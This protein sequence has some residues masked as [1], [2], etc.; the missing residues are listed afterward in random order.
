MT[1]HTRYVFPPMR[2]AGWEYHEG[3]RLTELPQVGD[4]LSLKPEPGNAHDAHAIEVF[5]RK[6]KIGYVPAYA[7]KRLHGIAARHDTICVTKR[8]DAPHGFLEFELSVPTPATLSALAAPR[9]PPVAE[10]SGTALLE[11]AVGAQLL[12]VLPETLTAAGADAATAAADVTWAFERFAEGATGGRYDAGVPISWSANQPVYLVREPAEARAHER[13]SVWLPG[14]RRLGFLHRNVGEEAITYLDARDPHRLHRAYLREASPGGD[15]FAESGLATFGLA[16]Y[17]LYPAGYASPVHSEKYDG[18]A[19]AERYPLHADDLLIRHPDAPQSL[20]TAPFL[21]GD[22]KELWVLK[23]RLPR[24]DNFD[25]DGKYLHTEDPQDADEAY[26]PFGKT[27]AAAAAPKPRLPRIPAGYEYQVQ[28]IYSTPYYEQV[29]GQSTE[30]L[31][32]VLR[33]R[34][35]ERGLPPAIAGLPDDSRSGLRY[36]DDTFVDEGLPHGHYVFAEAAA[37]DADLGAAEESLTPL[38][39]PRA[40]GAPDFRPAFDYRDWM[41]CGGVD[42][43]T[44]RRVRTLLARLPEPPPFPPITEAYT[45]EDRVRHVEA[46]LAAMSAELRTAVGQKCPVGREVPGRWA[47]WQDAEVPTDAALDWLWAKRWA[48][49]EAAWRSH[50]H[51]VEPKRYEYTK[52]VPYSSIESIT[53]LEGREAWGYGKSRLMSEPRVAGRE[54]GLGATQTLLL[55]RQHAHFT[56][57]YTLRAMLWAAREA[58]VWAGD[59]PLRMSIDFAPTLAPST[60]PQASLVDTSAELR[61][62]TVAERGREYAEARAFRV[63]VSVTWPG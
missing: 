23:R 36:F 6:H 51:A 25:T 21:P 53:R 60:W 55:P 3:P 28:W 24:Q 57:D 27:R 44:R 40:E 59:W 39:Y 31:L 9:L 18:N 15:A 5:W 52:H 41:S 61:F 42:V 63:L 35:L 1:Q 4:P 56:R 20:S 8:L 58:G 12:T 16:L 30:V 11:A 13:V 48:R 46:W 26:A 29:L 19:L 32:E 38:D 49:A 22:N 17:K 43:A 62:E 7:A 33:Q 2:V 34:S 14:A 47:Y 37:G 54:R 45:A 10:A 50:L